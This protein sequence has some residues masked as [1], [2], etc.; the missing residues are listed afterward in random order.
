MIMLTIRFAFGIVQNKP[1]LNDL[2]KLDLNDLD[3]QS[4]PP[5]AR[6]IIPCLKEM[7]SLRTSWGKYIPYLL[8]SCIVVSNHILLVVVVSCAFKSMAW[9]LGR[10][11][12]GSAPIAEIMNQ[13]DPFFGP[14]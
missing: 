9:I 3:S 14:L 13:I 4:Q 8:L 6:F 11:V 10:K 5:G 2:N 12:F 1:E 7:G